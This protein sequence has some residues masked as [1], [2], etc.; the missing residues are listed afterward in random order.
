MELKE[1]CDL[2]L[3]NKL[4]SPRNGNTYCNMAVDSIAKGFG[5]YEFDGLMADDIYQVMLTNES[6]KWDKVDGSDATIWALSN[7]LA[8]AALPSQTLKEAHGHV[9][10]IYP[11]GMQ[12]SGSLG[13]DVP[14]VANIGKTVGVMRSSEAFPVSDG[15]A[16]YFTYAG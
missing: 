6:G 16:D 10:V 15:E 14:M 4:F 1:L 8:I 9:A 5:C 13:R 2:A 12:M 3:K 7:G 11:L